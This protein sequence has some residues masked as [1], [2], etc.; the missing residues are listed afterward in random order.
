MFGVFQ[1]V[2]PLLGFGVALA[3]A[4][5]VEAYDHYISFVILAALG[6]KMGI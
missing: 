5:V 6:A 3:F 2:M 4:G 1:G